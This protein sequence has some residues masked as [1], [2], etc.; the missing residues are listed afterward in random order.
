LLRQNS[1]KILSTEVTNLIY[2]HHLVWLISKGL[3][4][5]HNLN[6]LLNA[7]TE[8]SKMSFSKSLKQGI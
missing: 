6:P 8:Q 5:H 4:I 2:K 3:L 7:L 1:F